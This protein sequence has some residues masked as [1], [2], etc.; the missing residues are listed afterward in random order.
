MPT[1]NPIMV[2]MGRTNTDI[3]K[4]STATCTA[5][6]A[7]AMASTPTTRGSK[8]AATAPKAR[9]NTTAAGTRG[10]DVGR[11]LRDGD[12]DGCGADLGHGLILYSL[13]RDGDARGEFLFPSFDDPV[14]NIGGD[15]DNENRDDAQRRPRPPAGR[16]LHEFV[17]AVG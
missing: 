7:Q 4:N 13:R 9:S 11:R 10:G 5:A 3:G 1:P 17:N 2:T 14:G 6:R 8:A 15:A 12:A 16:R